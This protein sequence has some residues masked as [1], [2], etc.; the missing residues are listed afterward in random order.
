MFR[1]SSSNL[2][3]Q[4][5]KCSGESTSRE[6]LLHLSESG[7]VRYMSLRQAGD[8]EDDRKGLERKSLSLRQGLSI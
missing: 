8:P 4:G 3:F 5:D 6:V 2:I 1:N 7:G